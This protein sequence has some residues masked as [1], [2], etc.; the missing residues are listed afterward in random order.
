MSEPNHP[1][2]FSEVFDELFGSSSKS[3]TISQHMSEIRFSISE[4]SSTLERI[5]TA[6]S[7]TAPNPNEIILKEIRNTLYAIFGVILVLAWRLS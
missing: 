5:E 3:Q 2:G 4:I 1:K 6:I 7:R